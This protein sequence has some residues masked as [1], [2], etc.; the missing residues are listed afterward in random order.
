VFC[1]K[2][3]LSPCTVP[4]LFCTLWTGEWG[5]NA[6]VQGAP[7]PHEGCRYM[8]RPRVAAYYDYC[9]SL[10]FI[11]FAFWIFTSDESLAVFNDNSV[12]F[13]DT[14]TM[15]NNYW[16]PPLFATITASKL[17]NFPGLWNLLL[18]I[19]AKAPSHH[20]QIQHW[21]ISQN[22]IVE[23]LAS[24]PHIKLT[25][26]LL[27]PRQFEIWKL[28]TFWSLPGLSGSHCTI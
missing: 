18:E 1:P 28:S 27:K 3:R 13:F 19:A 9:H 23:L 14:T 21:F 20:L 22:L 10:H 15:N 25:P 11:S 26:Q 16:L 12:F 24:Q 5:N 17:T 6:T 4:S 2:F 7:P 8:C